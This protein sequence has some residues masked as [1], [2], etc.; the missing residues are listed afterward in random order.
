MEIGEGRTKGA[1]TKEIILEFTDREEK[2]GSEADRS[3]CEHKALLWLPAE[4]IL[5]K[6]HTWLIH[7]G[8]Q[9]S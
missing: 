3:N 1:I 8:K 6:I 9:E 7:P 2:M 4:L 5:T